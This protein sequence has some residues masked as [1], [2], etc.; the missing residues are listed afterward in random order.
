[1]Q[2]I[3]S[4]RNPS[5]VEQAKAVFHD[6]SVSIISLDEAGIKGQATE[7]GTTL[8]ENATKKA[9]FVH[10]QHKSGIWAIADDTG[11]FIDALGGKPGVHTADWNGGN[12]ETI[13]MTEWILEQLKNVFDRSATFKTA[14]VIISPQGAQYL[15]VGE[16]RG[17]ILTV[18]REKTQPKMP[19]ASIFVPDG[20]EKTWG[21]MTVEEENAISHRGKAFRQARNFLEQLSEQERRLR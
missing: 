8:E 21:E 6:S 13:K 2:V 18:T 1:M 19:Y 7:D 9:M 4:T 3:L 11:I 12:K 17:K 16:V 14:V 10:N 15:F 20:S 5:K